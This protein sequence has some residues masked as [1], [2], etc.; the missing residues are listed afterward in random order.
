MQHA[1][2][3]AQKIV[4]FRF[5]TVKFY[6]RTMQ[7][8]IDGES[9]QI[10]AYLQQHRLGLSI[11]RCQHCGE[12][13]NCIGRWMF[14]NGTLDFCFFFCFYWKKKNFERKNEK[15][16]LSYEFGWKR[17]NWS[18]RLWEKEIYLIFHWI[19]RSGAEQI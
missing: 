4:V 18:I 15:F 2:R 7:S 16:N 3:R 1:N 9:T 17:T 5:R 14:E 13:K 12:F 10:H 8:N 19:L 6:Y 11:F